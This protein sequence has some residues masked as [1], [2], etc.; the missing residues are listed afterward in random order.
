[1]QADYP[2]KYPTVSWDPVH[3]KYPVS[4]FPETGDSRETVARRW[5]SQPEV[6]K[7]GATPIEEIK[8]YFRDYNV[9]KELTKSQQMQDF[10]YKTPESKR[11]N[12]PTSCTENMYV[13]PQSRRISERTPQKSAHTDSVMTYSFTSPALPSRLVTDKDQYKHPASLLSSY[14]EIEP[15]W[16]NDL[17]PLDT[18]HEGYE[19]YLDPYLTSS[20]LYH[21]PYTAEQL[22]RP[23]VSKDIITYYTLANIPWTR[24]PGPKK[25]DCWLP[26]SRPKSM[27]DRESLKEEFREIRTHNKLSWVP[28]TFRTESRDNYIPQSV[29]AYCHL[30]HLEEDVKNHYSRQ[31]AGLPANSKHEHTAQKIMYSTETSHVGSGRQICCT[32]D[33]HAAKNKRLVSKKTSS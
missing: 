4:K 12:K 31:T 20:R 13:Y 8:K 28:G 29:Q 10:N 24:T 5:T 21:R 19:K 6:L 26:R 2:E 3:V 30:D 27:Y 14:P 9:T 17:G 23:S 15:S 1:M 22:G 7:S 16:H 33:Q 11:F 25:E 18:T 32:V